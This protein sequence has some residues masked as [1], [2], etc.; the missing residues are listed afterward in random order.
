MHGGGYGSTFV[1]YYSRAM[2]VEPQ[3][4][5]RTLLDQHIAGDGEAFEALFLRH[6][7]KL[8]A[9][10]IRVT[11]NP[12]DASDALQEAMISAFPDA[13]SNTPRR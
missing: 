9:A 8:W 6:Q 2:V 13:T 11:R 4:S 3:D 7:D 1:P 12:E 10:A 5:D